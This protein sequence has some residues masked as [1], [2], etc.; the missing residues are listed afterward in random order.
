MLL[1]LNIFFLPRK[2]I[3]GKKLLLY[4]LKSEPCYGIGEALAGDALFTE[5]KDGL[6]ND[7][8]DLFFAGEDGIEIVS[9][10]NAFAPAAADVDPVS[11]G[12]VLDRLE[13]TFTDAAS[14]VVADR[15]I[16]GDL[17][18][19]DLCYVDRAV[20]FDLADLAAA[21]FL[22][23][24]LRDPLSDDAQVVEV[25]FHTVIRAAADCDLEFM[26]Q[27]D[28]AIAVEEA[29]MDLFGQAEGIDQSVLTGGS[30]AG[31][32]RANF[33]AG[34]AGFESGLHQIFA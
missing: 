24:D 25:R 13:R 34:A 4:V 28:A 18:V 19:D 22:R 16:N 17:A 14:A 30:L 29:L 23:V 31:D 8:E 3:I 20:V 21:T 27:F 2:Q 9:L 10:G 7:V 6:F 12:V 26:R 32:Y 11:G 33:G 5:E 15:F 1:R